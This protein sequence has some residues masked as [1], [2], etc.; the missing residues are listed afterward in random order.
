MSSMPANKFIKAGH[1]SVSVK[2]IE[3]IDDENPPENLRQLVDKMTKLLTQLLLI[4]KD[5]DNLICGSN[6]INY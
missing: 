2:D 5:M 4:L 1:S 3:V 6:S